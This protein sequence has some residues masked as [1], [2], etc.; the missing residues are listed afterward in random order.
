M[1]GQAIS[2]ESDVPSLPKARSTNWETVYQGYAATRTG[3]LCF[4]PSSTLLRLPSSGSRRV[5]V[6][7]PLSQPQHYF[8]RRAAGEEIVGFDGLVEAEGVGYQ[9]AEGDLAVHQE[10]GDSRCAEDPRARWRAVPSSAARRRVAGATGGPAEPGEPSVGG[11]RGPVAGR[12]M[13]RDGRSRPRAP[14]HPPAEGRF[15]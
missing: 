8:P 13:L 3:T 1:R 11:L 10:V 5:P 12:G 4:R 14:G 9:V 2:R 15:G 6:H 7:A